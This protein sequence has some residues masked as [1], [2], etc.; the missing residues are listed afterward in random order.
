[1]T[2]SRN[3]RSLTG[4]YALSIIDRRSYEELSPMPDTH[5]LR[6][7]SIVVSVTAALA[8]GACSSMP[9]SSG[10]SA[11][12]STKSPAPAGYQP[13]SDVPIPAGTK[14][15]T[16]KSLILGQADKWVGRMVL[17]TDRPSTQVYTYYIE[18]MPG[19]GWEQVSAVQGKTSIL[20]FTRADR[21]A[22]LE[23]TSG[24]LSGSE[25]AVTVS[26]RHVTSPAAP[27]KK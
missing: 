12:S 17:V 18:Q 20:T 13:V 7:L 1:V 21:A 9:G 2:I 27:E 6:R 19:F 15:N 8:L 25:V 24:T 10:G 4:F 11:A 23:I 22:T 5:S 14:I 26:P 3:F 16:D